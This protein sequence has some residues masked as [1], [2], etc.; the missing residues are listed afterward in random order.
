MSTIVVLHFLMYLSL[1]YGCNEH[2]QAERQNQLASTTCLSCSVAI[3][4]FIWHYSLIKKNW[5]GKNLPL[6]FYLPPFFFFSY[7]VFASLKRME[8]LS[9]WSVLILEA[10]LALT[11]SCVHWTEG[12]SLGVRGCLWWGVLWWGRTV[13]GLKGTVYPVSGFKSHLC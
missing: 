9:E 1:S 2:Y 4:P 8:S 12:S 13:S 11:N 10:F 3:L 6:C 7:Q 5:K